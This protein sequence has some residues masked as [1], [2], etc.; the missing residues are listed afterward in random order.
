M[1]ILGWV[2][3]F[4][5]NYCMRPFFWYQGRYYSG[6]L[7]MAHIGPLA[8]RISKLRRDQP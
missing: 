7:K 5:R 8:I 3:T 1:S 2:V 6:G 4:H